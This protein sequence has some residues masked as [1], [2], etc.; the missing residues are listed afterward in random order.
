MPAMKRITVEIEYAKH[1][2]WMQAHRENMS[3]LIRR[4]LD[5]AIAELEKE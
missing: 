3:A 1:W 4:G 2:E 5:L